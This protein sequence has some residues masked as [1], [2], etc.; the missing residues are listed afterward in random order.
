MGTIEEGRD[1]RRGP[2]LAH[3]G[4]NK[5]RCLS[6]TWYSRLLMFPVRYCAQLTFVLTKLPADVRYDIGAI[7]MHIL[8]IRVPL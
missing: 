8:R 7:S 6:L 4:S 3:S 2:R 5:V 1:Q